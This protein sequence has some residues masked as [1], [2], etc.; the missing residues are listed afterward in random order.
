MPTKK[1]TTRQSKFVEA[2]ADPTT[3]TQTEAALKSGYSPKRARA[4]A[5][6]LAGSPIINAAIESRKVELAQ[7]S[8]ITCALVIG[9]VVN[10]ALTSESDQVRLGAFKVLGSYL[11][12]E[13]KPDDN[14]DTI[15]RGKQQFEAAVQKLIDEGDSAQAARAFVIKAYPEAEKYLN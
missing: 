14:P 9:G 5:S 11:G 2:M 4:A 8:G 13:K 1:L 3:K 6:E 15:A 7:L 10:L 12:L